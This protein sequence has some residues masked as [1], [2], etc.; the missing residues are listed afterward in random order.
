MGIEVWFLGRD[1]NENKGRVKKTKREVL[2]VYTK[3]LYNSNL[4][5]VFQGLFCHYNLTGF[6]NDPRCALTG[7]VIIHIDGAEPE[8]DE[9]QA[10]IVYVVLSRLKYS[11]SLYIVY[12][13]IYLCSVTH[14]YENKNI[15]N[16]VLF[17]NFTEK[18]T[19]KSN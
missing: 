6:Y 5:I 2:A 18:Q 17:L 14:L 7:H 11:L 12:S 13:N 16:S 3:P 9:N 10:K 1:I 4:K 15:L 8:V 19:K